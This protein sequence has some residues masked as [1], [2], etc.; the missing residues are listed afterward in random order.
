M[1]HQKVAGKGHAELEL[2]LV[3]VGVVDLH[4]RREMTRLDRVGNDWDVP[5][6]PLLVCEAAADAGV[7]YATPTNRFW[8]AAL[9]AGLV[10]VDRDAFH[11]L[12]H[13]GVGVTDLVKR[14]SPNASVLRPAEYRAGAESH[15]GGASVGGAGEQLITCNVGRHEVGSELDARKFPVE[16]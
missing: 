12:R 14:A 8:P 4:P 2:S 3:R 6:Q 10:S 15:R 13:H 11:A 9:E 1:A 7:G 16:R 5:A